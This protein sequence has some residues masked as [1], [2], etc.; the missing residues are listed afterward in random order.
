MTTLRE[1]EQHLR[2]ALAHLYDPTFRPPEPLWA[3]MGCDPQQGVEAVQAVIVQAIKHFEPTPEIPSSARIRRFYELLSYRFIQGLTQEQT[4]EVLNLSL[5]HIRREQQ[6]AVGVLARRL[7]EQKQIEIL[8]MTERSQN[9]VQL[10]GV[11]ETEVESTAWRSQVRQELISLQKSAPGMVTEVK[12]AILSAAKLANALFPEHNVSLKVEP[13]QPN[14][15]VMLHPSVLNQILIT[16]IEKIAQPMSSGQITLQAKREDDQIKIVITG[17]PVAVEQPLYSDLIQEILNI[18]GGSSE[19]RTENER[20]S[21]ELRL[22]SA[23][24]ITVLVVDDNADLVHFYRRYTTGTRYQ[25]VHAAE[26]QRVFALIEDSP[27]DLIVLDV[28]LPDIDGW[29]L[30]TQL[31]EHPS[32]QATPIIVCSVV[33]REKLA[34]ALGAA[35][36][37]PKP[38]R[39]EQFIQ[40]LDQTLNR[41][42]T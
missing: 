5:R 32:T 20:V 30:L 10:P 13:V 29:E 23:H 28:M 12:V 26:G 38:V 11:T 35:M 34:L 7:W 14:L 31:R 40:A 36:V 16:A 8:T 18:V 22:P 2:E 3:V 4:A 37:V 9:G 24:K 15:A 39:Y 27:P 41:V 42:A 6:R 25:I 21:I 19:V 33:R 17:Q 1:F